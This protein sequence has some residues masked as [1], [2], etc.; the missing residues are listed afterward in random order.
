MEGS[1]VPSN[2]SVATQPNGG[3]LPDQ[4]AGTLPRKAPLKVRNVAAARE[5]RRRRRLWLIAGAGLAINAL[6]WTRLF[7][8]DPVG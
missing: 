5:G 3:G 1:T 7:E 6:V 8:G 4:D 2:I